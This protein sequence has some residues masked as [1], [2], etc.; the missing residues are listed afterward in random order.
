MN[1]FNLYCDIH[2]LSQI[3]CKSCLEAH[4][5]K[6]AREAA[7]MC[8]SQMILCTLKQTTCLKCSDKITHPN[9]SAINRLLREISTPE[10]K[11]NLKEAIK[12]SKSLRI[13]KRF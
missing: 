3:S 2:G 8:L 12:L 10:L 1:L 13:N 4:K 9:Y 7:E 11:Q 6:V 5:Q